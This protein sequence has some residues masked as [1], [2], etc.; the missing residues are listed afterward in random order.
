M[1]Q[2]NPKKNKRLFIR[3]S[4]LTI[5]IVQCI[6]TIN[7][8]SPFDPR[9]DADVLYKAMKGLGTD[10][11]EVISILCRR[12]SYQ[13]AAISQIYKSNYNEVYLTVLLNCWLLFCYNEYLI[14]C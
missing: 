8:N 12:T 2:V 11:N 3:N 6:P 1:E 4:F 14:I 5:L 10:E 13:R 7:G 9:A